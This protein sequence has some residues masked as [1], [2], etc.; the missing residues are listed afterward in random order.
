VARKL[1]LV[2]DST[3]AAHPEPTGIGIYSRKLTAALAEK[4]TTAEDSPFRLLLGIRPRAYLRWVGKRNWPAPCGVRLLLDPWFRYPPAELFHGLS[5]RLPKFSYPAQVFTLHDRYPLVS[6]E[7]ASPEFRRLL[8]E[9]IE[10]GIRRADRI[11]AVSEAVRQR[12]LWYDASLEPKIRVV[13]HAVD[14]PQ[15]ATA[16]QTAAFRS[17]A[18]GLSPQERFFLN[19]GAIQVRKNISN[20]ALA[21]K[22]VPGYRLVLAGADGYGAEKIHALIREEGLTDRILVLGRVPLAVL[23]LLYSSASALLFP[24]LEEGFGLPILEAM[25]YGLPVIT[26]DVSAT[27]EIAGDA[28]ILVDPHSV[29]EISEA[30]RRV[31][32]DQ[33][34]AQELAQK[35]RG[36][37]S[38]FSWEKCAAQTLAVYQEALGE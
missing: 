11:I 7:Y 30:L 28:A 6:E 17:H 5:Q 27:K 38:Q 25:S 23:R 4:M 1:R 10:D 3:D 33:D 32:E 29:P 2:L 37:A 12:L 16:E 8:A 9:R 22:Q 21:L 15:L 14:P 35:G 36:R 13:H 20:M 18:L 31:M 26:S 34:L 19:V 24:S